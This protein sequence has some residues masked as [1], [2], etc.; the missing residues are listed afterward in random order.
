MAG[1]AVASSQN[2]SRLPANNAQPGLVLAVTVFF[3]FGGITNL[4]DILIPKLKALFALNYAEATMVQFAFFTAYAVFSIPAGNLVTRL[5][6][7][8]VIVGG[9]VLMAAV[10]LLFTS[11]AQSGLFIAFLACLFL[12]GAGI[13]ALQVAVNPLITSLGDPAT[14]HSR[15]T[16]AQFFNALGVFLMVRYGAELILGAAAKDPAADLTADALQS[17]RAE[18]S[19]VIGQA[20]LG[21]ALVLIVIAVLFWWR[22]RDLPAHA[23]AGVYFADSIALLRLPRLAFGVAAIFCYVGA[24]VAIA[25]LMINYL[26]QASVL[27][28]D[29]ETAGILLSYYWL[30][31][32]IGRFFG[33]FLLRRV[34]PAK[35]LLRYALVAIVLVLISMMTSGA[36]AGYTLIAVGLT[37]SI[38]FPTIFSLAVEG[39]GNK[40]PQGSGLLCTAIVGGAVIPVIAGSVADHTSLAA[41]LIVPAVCYALIAGFGW[42]ARRSI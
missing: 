3:L 37:N 36:L 12:L 13:T 1:Q 15:L 32:L 33:G 4:N 2:T 20:Y 35:L 41:A 27:N 29:L 18:Q 34:A 19:M 17:F 6:Y 42:F 16:F 24:E 7:T 31:A 9:F 39:L 10:C 23:T 5:G 40:A 26:H 21:I 14:A 8:K 22:R 28:V 25:S 38:M 11:A 30:G